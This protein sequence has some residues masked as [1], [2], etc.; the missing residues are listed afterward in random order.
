M[1][2]ENSEL[3]RQLN[4]E[5]QQLLAEKPDHF[6]AIRNVRE[7]LRAIDRAESLLACMTNAEQEVEKPGELAE[8]EQEPASTIDESK[9][10]QILSN[11]DS[12]ADEL[13]NALK[14]LKDSREARA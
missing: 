12:T 1:S 6:V 3:K 14:V 7:K 2:N 4:E 5:L 13:L 10:R 11:K 8:A 9:A